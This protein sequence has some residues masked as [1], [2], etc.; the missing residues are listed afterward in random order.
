MHTMVS[1]LASFGTALGLGT[2]YGVLSEY[3]RLGLLYAKWKGIGKPMAYSKVAECLQQILSAE[4]NNVSGL[5]SKGSVDTIVEF[6]DK[7]LD[8]AWMVDESIAT[9]MFVQMIQQS[10][11]YAIHSSHA[12]SIGTIGNVYSGSM[13]LSGTESS[14]IAVASESVDRPSRGF[15][16]AEVGQNIPTVAFN[17]MRGA[18]RRLDEVNRSLMRNVDNLLDEWNDV[19]L[20]YYRQYHTLSRERFNNAVI[21]KETATDRAYSLLEQAGNEFLAR[22]SEEM[23]TLEGAKSWYDSGLMTAEELQDIAIRLQPEVE[24]S[25]ENYDTIKEEILDA[26]DETIEDWDDKIEQALGDLQD[27]E[28]K[29]ATLIRSIF[30]TIFDDVVD[31]ATEIVS[32][33]DSTIKDICAYRNVIP[34]VEVSL[35][36]RVIEPLEEDVTELDLSFVKYGKW[37]QVG[38]ETLVFEYEYLRAVRWVQVEATPSKYMPT[39]PYDEI[40]VRSRVQVSGYEMEYPYDTL[41]DIQGVQ[42]A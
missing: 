11:A 37:E 18:N 7:T 23:D 31:F 32:R 34:S 42:V 39:Y 19:V 25:E 20:T 38:S 5:S 12:G 3:A 28:T 6:I 8:F 2:G 17:L 33:V 10:I 13:Y 27:N 36:N 4:K 21:M 30:D 22:I 15:L 35:L 29:Y 9:Q 14:E 40:P 1:P 41:P 16:G 26:I 24:A